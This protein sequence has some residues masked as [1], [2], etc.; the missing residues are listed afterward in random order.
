MT[1][2]LFIFI[3]KHQKMFF[4]YFSRSDLLLHSYL[5]FDFLVDFSIKPFHFNNQLSFDIISNLNLCGFDNSFY[6]NIILLA[7]NLYTCKLLIIEQSRDYYR[8]LLAMNPWTWDLG[9]H[10]HSA[11][12]G[13]SLPCEG[14]LVK[15]LMCLHSLHDRRQDLIFLCG[16]RGPH[17]DQSDWSNLTLQHQ[18]SVTQ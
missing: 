6:L 13:T 12:R 11:P 5:F 16:L 9:P 18:F 17:F 10:V 4:F 14:C 3:K 7:T 2:D 15:R 8:P 1:L